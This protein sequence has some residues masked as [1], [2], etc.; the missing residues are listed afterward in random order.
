[1]DQCMIDI[2]HIPNIKEGDEV[3]IL[4]KQKDE[5]ITIYE[6]CELAD[7]IPNEILTSIGNR[8]NRTYI[9]LNN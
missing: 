2:T 7:T 8:V 1:M 6:I 5:K 9:T 4:G 3:I